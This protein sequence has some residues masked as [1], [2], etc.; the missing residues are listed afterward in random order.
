MIQTGTKKPTYG[1]NS[2]YQSNPFAN[3]LAET[4]QHLGASPQTTGLDPFSE[5]LFKSGNAFDT[6]SQSPFNQQEMLEKQRLDL[7]KK[8]RTERLRRRLHEQINPVDLYSV[9][10]AREAQVKKQ[11]EETLKEI[12]LLYKETQAF[13]KEVDIAV[14]KE[15]VSPGQ[16]GK[17]YFSFFTQLRNFIRLWRQRIQSAR[18]WARQAQAFQQRKKQAAAGF[19]A[20]GHRK[21]KAV[22]DT[23][24]HER[25]NAYGAG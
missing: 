23:M 1:Q 21:T 20:Q 18:T 10:N 13:E 4:E 17:Y 15:V 25:S 2:G 7:E 8:Q 22:H 9:Y 19:G 14:E 3:A 11:M 12:K 5:A 6:T 24:H 16:T